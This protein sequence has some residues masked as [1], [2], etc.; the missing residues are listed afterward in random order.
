M[1]LRI[2]HILIGISVFVRLDAQIQPDKIYPVLFHD[3]QTS[4]LFEDS[5][6][7]PDCIPIIN[8][9]IVDSLYQIEK[10]R[11]DFNLEDYISTYFIKP[12]KSFEFTSDT[13]VDIIEHINMLWDHLQR[14][15]TESK[16]TLIGLPNKYVVP[17]GRF[18][19]VYYWDTYFTMLGL[20]ESGHTDLIKS[21]IDNFS[22]LIDTF[23]HIPNGNR[24]YYVSRSQPPFFSLMVD[25][26][27]AI[28]GDKVY[29]QYLEQLEKEYQFWMSGQEMLIEDLSAHRRVVRLPGDHILNRYWDDD[30]SPRPE[31]YKEDLMLAHLSPEHD[32]V[33]F[34]N[35][36]AACESGWDFSCRWLNDSQSLETI[37]TTKILPI[38]LNCL[39]YNLE[40]VLG[41]AY[42]LLDN[43][44]KSKQYSSL[45]KKRAKAIDRFFWRKKQGFFVDYHWV[46]EWQNMPNHLAG[47][48]PLFFNI[49]S[50]K[51]AKQTA[52]YLQEK[53]LTEGGLLTTYYNTGQQ[54]DSPNGW[55]PLQY[56]AI[57]GLAI[58]G[59]DDLANDIANRW[60]SLIQKIYKEQGKLLEKY[61][62][63]DLDVKSGG[64]E[65]PTQDGF[66]WT[67]GV[68]QLLDKSDS[69]K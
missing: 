29:L 16:G 63:K 38:D 1:R 40:K 65:Y 14:K 36:R 34:R 23:G 48:Y 11:T 6:V 35:I 41:K 67:N 30:P 7:F 56:I 18:R 28:E 42:S 26:Y 54:W 15:T 62:V 57:K 9:A 20:K 69:I 53:F 51:Q 64:G 61:N 8:P 45:A 66:G 44:E 32:S 17:G 19:E 10:Q 43:K 68:Y 60:M 50:K 55:A 33:D 21:M 47:V 52:A 22:F 3:V 37:E 59:H 27:A 49:A 5:K 31:A 12:K 2:L 13:T 46:L 25:L 4:N 58:Y 39:M 24:T